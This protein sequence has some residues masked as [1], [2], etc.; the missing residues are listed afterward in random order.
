[1]GCFS[2]VNPYMYWKFGVKRFDTEI[3]LTGLLAISLTKLLF[4]FFD[5][6]LGKSGELIDVLNS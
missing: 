6:F 5:S 2:G 3:G 4:S 1:M